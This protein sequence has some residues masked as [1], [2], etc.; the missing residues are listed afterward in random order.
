[1]SAL[2]VNLNNLQNMIPAKIKNIEEADKKQG[3]YSDRL[4]KPCYI[5]GPNNPVPQTDHANLKNTLANIKNRTADPKDNL[6]TR[7]LNIEAL[8]SAIP[9]PN[10]EPEHTNCVRKII[11]LTLEVDTKLPDVGHL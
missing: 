11:R 4:A 3:L 2:E 6:P 8:L 5:K 9:S 7:V 10:Q 1:M